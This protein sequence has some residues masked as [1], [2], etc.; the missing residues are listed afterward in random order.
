M[1][2]TLLSRT[3]PAGR[4]RTSV[5]ERAHRILRAFDQSA[6]YLTVSE[7]C[8]I[9]GLPMTTAHRIVLEMVSVGLLE[10]DESGRLS[11][12]LECWRIG[13]CA[14]RASGLQQ[15][16]LPFMKDLHATTGFPIHLAVLKGYEVLFV[17]NLHS[18]PPHERPQ[19]RIGAEYPPHVTAVGKAL[20]AHQSSGY[21]ADYLDYWRKNLAGKG[22]TYGPPT[23]TILRQD[24]AKVRTEGIAVSDRQA[25][26]DAVA[27]GAPVKGETGESIGA[28]SIIVPQGVNYA[29]YALLVRTTARS[30]QRMVHAP[31]EQ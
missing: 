10:R 14:P 5:L 7:I 8:W 23:E 16:A 20:L 12:S 1:S 29:P 24:L 30:V 25:S 27:V 11:I 18:D 13:L 19:P 9:T 4:P 2:R 26:K 21:L 17:E 6:R 15:V 3:A 28:L 22:G 31:P